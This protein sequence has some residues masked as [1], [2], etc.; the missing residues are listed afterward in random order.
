MLHV[1]KV[2]TVQRRT[3]VNHACLPSTLIKIVHDRFP[4]VVGPGAAAMKEVF[5]IIVVGVYC[6]DRPETT[7][8]EPLIRASGG[9]AGRS[10]YAGTE[11]IT[12]DGT[13]PFT[14]ILRCVADPNGLLWRREEQQNREFCLMHD[15]LYINHIHFIGQHPHTACWGTTH[16]DI[17]NVTDHVVDAD[18]EQ[19]GCRLAE[20]L[21]SFDLGNIV[22]VSIF[23][24]TFWRQ[25]GFIP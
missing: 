9:P 14:S 7:C 1:W 24:R 11:L 12:K 19:A 22:T 20:R 25:I 18:K 17:V 4:R 6:A 15:A 8:N 2:G 21:T 13:I 5:G 23:A 10:G 16:A 3:V